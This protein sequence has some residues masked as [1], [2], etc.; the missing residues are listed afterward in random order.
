MKLIL[1]GNTTCQHKAQGQNNISFHVST[2]YRASHERAAK[3]V[4]PKKGLAHALLLSFS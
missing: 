4:P 1:V 2:S 3:T